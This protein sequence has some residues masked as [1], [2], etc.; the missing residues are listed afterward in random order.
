MDILENYSKRLWRAYHRIHSNVALR[1]RRRVIDQSTY[2]SLS[3]TVYEIK[4]LC[5]LV[6]AQLAAWKDGRRPLRPVNPYAAYTVDRV[7]SLDFVHMCP[8]IQRFMDRAGILYARV[9]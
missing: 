1:R 9:M 8:D 4:R 6:D 3:K 7:F 2:A 5:M